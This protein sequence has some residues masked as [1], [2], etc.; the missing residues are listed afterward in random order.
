MT[1]SEN[2]KHAYDT[3]LKPLPKTTRKV[4]CVEL[5]KDFSSPYKAALY[6]IQTEKLTANYRSIANNIN[7]VCKKERTTAYKYHWQFIQ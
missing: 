4:H 5:N 2:I 6:L 3:N 1:Y 7:G